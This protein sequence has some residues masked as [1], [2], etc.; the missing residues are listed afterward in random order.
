MHLCAAGDCPWLR[1]TVVSVHISSADQECWVRHMLRLYTK[2]VS[3]S[4][5]SRCTIH[6][7]YP[8]VAGSTRSRSLGAPGRYT[9]RQM[10]MPACR[11]ARQV[12]TSIG[13]CRTPH[14]QANHEFGGT[15][16]KVST[17]SVFPGCMRACL[18]PPLRYML[19]VDLAWL[20]AQCRRAGVVGCT[21]IL[22]P[23]DCFEYHRC[24]IRQCPLATAFEVQ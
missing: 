10:C 7:G 18:I 22:K 15:S 20:L 5:T 2:E 21:P 24:T 17:R 8:L 9:M 1:Q 19:N 13:A 23:G 11:E 12:S 16:R 6:N 3:Q 14:L 4:T